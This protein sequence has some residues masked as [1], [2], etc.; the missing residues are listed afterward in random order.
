TQT[1]LELGHLLSVAV[2]GLLHASPRRLPINSGLR[3][4]PQSTSDS[5]PSDHRGAAQTVPR[6]PVLADV[7]AQGSDR[8]TGAG[9]SGSSGLT[10][11]LRRVSGALHVARVRAD[12]SL[13]TDYERTIRHEEPPSKSV[14]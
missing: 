8:P 10:D 14:L 2:V 3:G 12:L 7:R 9:R 1:L 4:K 13:Q 6:V 11:T 5:R